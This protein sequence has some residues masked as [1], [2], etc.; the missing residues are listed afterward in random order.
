VAGRCD[1]QR[2]HGLVTNQVFIYLYI[3]SSWGEKG[4][5]MGVAD[6]RPISN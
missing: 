2:D 3:Y 1:D 6:E 4:E 5:L